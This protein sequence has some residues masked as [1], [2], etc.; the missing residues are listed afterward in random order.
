MGGFPLGDIARLIFQVF[1]Y[2]FVHMLFWLVIIL[3][4]SQYRKMIKRERQLF[5]AAK[6]KAGKQTLI[7]AFFGIGAGIIASFIL[8]SLG[9][10]LLHVGIIYVWPFVILLMIVHPRYM[11]FAY[12]GGVVSLLSLILSFFA[13]YW[14]QLYE[15]SFI[16]GIMNVDVPGLISLIAVLHL[17]EA[18]LILFSGSIDP[19]PLYIKY[20][21]R[22]VVGGFS[23]QKFWPLPIVGLVTLM[24]QEADFLGIVA[25]V[26]PEWMPDW[27]PV[28]G[29]EVVAPPGEEV[30]YTMLPL[31]AGLGYGDISVSTTP[32]EKSL[33]SGR[34]LAV[35]SIVL[36][37][38]AVSAVYFSPLA[39]LAA[40][41]SPVGHELLII[42]GRKEEFSKAPLYES[43]GRGVKVLDVYTDGLAA[44]LGLKAGDTILQVNDVPVMGEGDFR[45]LVYASQPYLKLDVLTVNGERKLLKSPVFA[46]RPR[47]GL[48]LAPGAGRS[49]GRYVEMKDKNRISNLFRNLKGILKRFR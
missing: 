49:S 32:R 36:L 26:G 14:P 31:V 21:N 2:T 3:V 43:G 16:R 8:V 34:Y 10:N 23:L 24:P 33:Q 20:G 38:V 7:S 22:G 37:V 19:S 44:E 29:P 9:I 41:L 5:G 47:I 11:C 28:V 42:R 6:N 39:W 18:L 4:F 17:T 25:M 30:V 45:T 46:D 12:G 48:I 40:I 15:I 27:W 13:Q 1:P 35:Y